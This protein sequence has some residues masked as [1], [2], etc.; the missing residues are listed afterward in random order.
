MTK[1]IS[2]S[3]IWG[4]K[5]LLSNILAQIVT[6]NLETEISTSNTKLLGWSFLCTE[7]AVE[8]QKPQSLDTSGRFFLLDQWLSTKA[9]SYRYC[10]VEGKIKCMYMLLFKQN[11]SPPV[12]CNLVDLVSLVSAT[13]TC[14][15][16]KF[17]MSDSKSFDSSSDEALIV[18]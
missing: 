7:C 5:E 6:R 18:W 16:I 2:N 3:G 4:Q 8:R 13:N 17:C 15:T 12:F 9:P 10:P 14:H 1:K 11:T